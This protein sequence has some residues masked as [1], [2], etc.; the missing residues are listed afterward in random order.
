MLTF[1]MKRGFGGQ[2]DGVKTVCDEKET[3]FCALADCK[4]AAYW[5]EFEMEAPIDDTYIMVPGCAYDGNRFETV[6]RKYPPMFLESEMGVDVPVRMTQVPHLEPQGDSFMDVTTG[7]LTVPC[8]CV[9][10]KSLQ[11][12]FILWFEQGEHG[13]N[14]GVTLEQTGDRLAIRLQAPA[15]RRLVYRWYE[16]IPSLRENPGADAPLCVRAGEETVIRHQAHT[17]PCQDIA[18]LYS[19]F[20]DLR[21][22]NSQV[23]EQ[24][25]LPFSAFWDLAQD[26]MNHRYFVEKEGFFSELETNEMPEGR[27][28]AGWVGCGM[29]TI[30]FLADG[31][32]ESR[33]NALRTLQFA[34]N[35]QSAAGWYYPAYRQGG[36]TF[37]DFHYHGN[38]NKTGMVR[39]HADL[40]YFMCKQWI[41]LEKDGR[42]TESAV[43]Q[44]IRSSA[45]RAADALVTL[46]KTYGQ[47]G[48]FLNVETGQILVG[49]TASGGIASAALCAAYQISGEEEYLETARQIGE[50]YY[51]TAIQTGLTNGG[52][53]EIL[54]APDSESCA[55]LLESYM[56]LY[57]TE[58]DKKWLEYAGDTAHQLSSWV[59]SYDYRYPADCRFGKMG[60]HTAGSVWANVQNK[61]S[62][63][64]L[65][66]LSAASFL[67][68][69]RAT[70]D[71]RYLEM[72]RQISH[73]IPQVVSYPQ[74]PMYP[75]PGTPWG[76]EPLEFGSMCERVNMS[77]WEGNEN[78]GDAI[79][80][81]SNWPQSALMLTWTEI[82]G[83]YVVPERE[84]V[85]V[86]DHVKAWLEGKKLWIENPTEMPARVKVMAENAESMTQPLGLCWQERFRIVEVQAG[87][88]V[89]VEM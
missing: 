55:G 35:L 75:M 67:K 11:E 62:A 50:F 17:F 64:G 89:C 86:S 84:I 6:L 81:P 52:P 47:L 8:V 68:L 4:D 26:L 57:E 59:V 27:W 33:R 9:F 87:A 83:V 30:S 37:D 42:E 74:R 25:N 20:F 32:E 56:V 10:R 1:E 2:P 73:F 7:D 34:A 12:G 60:I 28:Q 48:Q 16:G 23:G 69:F 29:S 72:M 39:K 13:L 76:E 53:G 51:R 24:A 79:F 41:M 80:G 85:A 44:Q 36:V 38:A 70:G 82:P 15:K 5:V 40:T 46:W 14:H 71:Q 65:C 58:G 22:Q 45:L 77:D 78:V 19:V 3:R 63:P 88:R 54:Q 31:N 21:D 43:R 49:G 18:E 66:T 61:H